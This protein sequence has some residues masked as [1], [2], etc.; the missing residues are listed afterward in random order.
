MPLVESR[1]IRANYRYSELDDR[2]MKEVG[3]RRNR[4]PKNC[5]AALNG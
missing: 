1:P 5:G 4:V 2:T 3:Q